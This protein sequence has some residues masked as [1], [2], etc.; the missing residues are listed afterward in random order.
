MHVVQLLAKTNQFNLTSRRH[1]RDDV[2]I[3]LDTPGSIGIT[4]RVRDRFGDHG[5][6]SVMIGVPDEQ[7]PGDTA[8]IDTWLM[9]CRVIGR[10]VEHF[11][12]G[13]FLGRAQARGYR[14]VL[15]EYIPTKKNAQVAGLYAELGF[16]PLAG[17]GNATAR[18]EL[19]LD[20]DGVAWPK[21]LVR[22]ER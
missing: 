5:L 3:L 19:R 18:F 9:S 8:R 11:F 4:I 13:E 21:T 12:L 10:T 14:R 2:L 22:P 6:V 7:T 16:A 17:H 1:T 20:V 15:G